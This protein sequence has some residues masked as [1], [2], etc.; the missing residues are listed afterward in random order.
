MH[1]TRSLTGWLARW[2][3]MASA[4]ILGIM[5]VAIASLGYNSARRVAD[6]AAEGQAELLL[7]QLRLGGGMAGVTSEDLEKIVS[8]HTD[9]GLR[10]LALVQESGRVI[11]KGGHQAGNEVT[12]NDLPSNR[13]M[14]KIGKRLRLLT[15][16]LL[17]RGRHPRPAGSPAEPPFLRS[18]DHRPPRPIDSLNGFNKSRFNEM[19]LSDR[20][21]GGDRRPQRRPPPRNATENLRP[22]HPPWIVIEFEPTLPLQLKTRAMATVILSLVVSLLFMGAAIVSWRLSMRADR[23]AVRSEQQ[24]RLAS[25]GEMSAVMAHEIRNPLASLK[26][27]AQLLAERFSPDSPERKK[28]DQVVQEAVRLEQLTND[29]LDFSRPL[30]IR[31]REINPEDLLADAVGALADGSLKIELAEAPPVWVLDPARMRQVLINLLRNAVQASPESMQVTARVCTENDRLCFVIRDYGPGI[32]Q[33][34]EENI[35]EP[36][37]TGRVRGVGLGLAVARR[38]V[39]L[40]GGSIKVSN[41]QDGGAEFKVIIPAGECNFETGNR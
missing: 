11:A 24:R 27:H 12:A 37:H 14:I 35:F 28:S 22:P 20:R 4:L 32:S 18:D 2:G 19:P 23:E 34:D 38:I 16:G 3:L 30:E 6:A 13:R 33:G 40:H 5:L 41:H 21:P 26:G 9:L 15:P 25:L 7:R 10:Y 29:L 1:E 8:Y 31:L 17:P 36:F 39:E